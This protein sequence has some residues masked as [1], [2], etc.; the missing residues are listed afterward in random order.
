MPLKLISLLLIIGLSQSSYG[1]DTLQLLN[2]KEKIVKITYET[3]SFIVYKKIKDEDT[4]DLS[5][6]KSYDKND[7][8]RISYL[9]PNG[10]DSVQKITQVYK[11]D[12]MMG[13]YFTVKE[14]E[15]FLYG[16]TQARKNSKSIK[17]GLIGF[18][19]GLASG[20]LGS[21][22]GLAPVTGYST[23]SGI[24]SMTPITN[25]KNPAALNNLHFIAGYKEASRKKQALYS[26]IGSITGFIAS[27]F[28]LDYLIK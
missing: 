18:E 21:F 27:I 20:F 10:V 13:D 4:T 8:F 14:M 25:N 24:P 11:V 22:W 1:Q 12:S 5:K 6:D 26:A 19:V 7:I 9:F 15:M 3:P 2:G 28:V 23:L 16:K 17:Y